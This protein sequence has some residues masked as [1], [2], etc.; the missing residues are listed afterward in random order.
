MSRSARDNHEEKITIVLLFSL[1]IAVAWLYFAPRIRVDLAARQHDPARMTLTRFGMMEKSFRR[2]SNKIECGL[3][4]LEDG[5]EVKYWFVSKHVQPGLGLTRFD[6]PDGETAY[7]SGA[8]CCEMALG[9]EGVADKA[10][11]LAFIAKWD[12][13][14]P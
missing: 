2:L 7:L 12:G 14:M 8:F 9:G 5:S 10:A 4:H 13:R 6:F 11:L 1:M 3:I